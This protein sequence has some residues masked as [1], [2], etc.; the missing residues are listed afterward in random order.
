[1][2]IP[3]RIS[4]LSRI[5]VLF[6]WIVLVFPLGAGEPVDDASQFYGQVQK[7]ILDAKTLQV[8]FTSIFETLQK[9]Q[10]VKST[11]SIKGEGSLVMA[12]GNRCKFLFDWSEEGSDKK[13]SWIAIS[14]GK[15][16]SMTRNGFFSK[17]IEPETLEWKTPLDRCLKADLLG[18]G[19]MSGGTFHG[20]SYYPKDKTVSRTLPYEIKNCRFQK[21]EMS[22][23]RKTQ[24]IRYHLNSY[25]PM[26]VT[27]WIDTQTRLPVKR[28]RVWSGVA[29][30]HTKTETYSDWVLDGMIDPI[31]FKLP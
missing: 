28:V 15:R 31:S 19:L 21:E 2:D 20:Y 5:L 4:K 11:K 26:S 23:D 12:E 16:I 6:A 13:F 29:G 24:V 22:G 14:D 17:E 1:M 10:K 3:N 18:S 9:G 25:P 27:V 30:D 7:Q 8:K